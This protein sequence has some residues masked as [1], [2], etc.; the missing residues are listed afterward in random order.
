MICRKP[1]SW[2]G[3]Q[4]HEI[5]RRSRAPNRWGHPC[6]YLLTCQSC[7]DGRLATMRYADQLAYKLRCDPLNYDLTQFMLIADPRGVA[8]SLVSPDDVSSA[9]ASHLDSHF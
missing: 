8:P 6:N 1:E 4:I 2:P 3:L 7:H 5:V 9:L